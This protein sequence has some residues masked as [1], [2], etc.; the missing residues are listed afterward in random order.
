MATETA[1]QS[2]NALAEGQTFV[3]HEVYA[4]SEQKS[5]EFYTQCLDFGTVEFPMGERSYK[6]LTRNNIPVA[7]V[8][9]TDASEMADVPPHWSTFISVD[10]VDARLAKCQEAGAKLMYGPMDVPTVGRMA[11]IADP[12]GAHVWIFKSSN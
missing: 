10:D 3:W 11:L 12:Q 4:P 9:G 8:V 5:I 6:M 7:G 1:D 2:G